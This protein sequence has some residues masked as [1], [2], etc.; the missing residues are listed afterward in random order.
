MAPEV[1]SSNPAGVPAGFMT[2]FAGT[3]KYNFKADKSFEG[4]MTSGTYTFDDGKLTMNTTKMGTTALPKPQTMSG[5]FSAD[6]KTLTLH[7][8]DIDKVA[9][10]LKVSNLDFLKNIKMVRDE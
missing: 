5:E 10:L 1:A 2:G 4:S 9:K 3:F 8:P 6:G 7:P